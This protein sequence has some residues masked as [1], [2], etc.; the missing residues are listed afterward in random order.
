MD[1]PLNKGNDN[2]AKREENNMY[3]FWMWENTRENT[4]FDQEKI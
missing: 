4:N 2:T 1:C 3:S